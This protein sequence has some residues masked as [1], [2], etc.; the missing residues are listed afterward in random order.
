MDDKSIRDQIKE[1]SLSELGEVVKIALSEMY[2]KLRSEEGFGLEQYCL[3][4][5]IGCEEY[6]VSVC[7]ID[8]PNYSGIQYKNTYDF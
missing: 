7:I 1:L 3:V 4:S 8:G 2:S 6:D 5:S